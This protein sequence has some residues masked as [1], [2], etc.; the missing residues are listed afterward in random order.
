MTEKYNKTM[1]HI[2]LKI[3][4]AKLK[5]DLSIKHKQWISTSTAS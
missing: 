5:W 3:N 4:L 1:T 2:L